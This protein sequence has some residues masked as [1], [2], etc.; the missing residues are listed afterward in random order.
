MSSRSGSSV[1]VG[2]F[3]GCFRA[4]HDEFA[5]RK[6]SGQFRN[7]LRAVFGTH[8]APLQRKFQSDY[9]ADS[10]IIR[11]VLERFTDAFRAHFQRELGKI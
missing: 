2:R 8:L 10:T 11:S 7:R 4:V 1:V 3:Q 6:L 9:R 5:T